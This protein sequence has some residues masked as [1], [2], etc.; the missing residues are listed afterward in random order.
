MQNNDLLF[1]PTNIINNCQNKQNFFNTYL[2]NAHFQTCK[3]GWMLLFLDWGAEQGKKSI[4][5]GK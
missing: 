3:A 1:S 5:K 2:K 4:I